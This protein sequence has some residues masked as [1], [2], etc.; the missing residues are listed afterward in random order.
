MFRQLFDDQSRICSDHRA[1]AFGRALSRIRVGPIGRFR[2][3]VMFII[4]KLN[5]AGS[6][7]M[8][9]AWPVNSACELC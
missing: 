9:T 1:N 6:E 2:A 5:P 7:L 8:E 4:N 3:D